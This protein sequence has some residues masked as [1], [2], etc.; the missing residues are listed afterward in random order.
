MINNQLPEIV[1]EVA[2][3]VIT[4]VEEVEEV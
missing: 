2:E 1:E 4:Q 3:P